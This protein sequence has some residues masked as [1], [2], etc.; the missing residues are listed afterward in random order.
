MTNCFMHIYIYI[1][2]YIKNS[3]IPIIKW[4]QVTKS[5]S[6]NIQETYFRF[7]EWTKSSSDLDQHYTELLNLWELHL[8]FSAQ[9]PRVQKWP[10]AGFLQYILH[11]KTLTEKTGSTVSQYSSLCDFYTHLMKR[12]TSVNIWKSSENAL[13][14]ISLFDWCFGSQI[15]FTEALKG[16]KTKKQEAAKWTRA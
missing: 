16:R 7:V 8:L 11:V 1:H 2:T 15:R 12:K 14:I 13:L 6:N 10:I 5:T 4:T 3:P 9:L